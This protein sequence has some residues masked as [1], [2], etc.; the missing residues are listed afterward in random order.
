MI[1]QVAIVLSE[2]YLDVLPLPAFGPQAPK[3]LLSHWSESI[4]E[5]RQKLLHTRCI[6]LKIS[7]LECLVD[8]LFVE[9]GPANL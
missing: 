4:L 3:E 1:D 7:G 2:Q 8:A 5:D 6:E 9:E